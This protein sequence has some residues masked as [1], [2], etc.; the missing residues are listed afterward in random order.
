RWVTSAVFCKDPSPFPHTAHYDDLDRRCG[1]RRGDAYGHRFAGRPHQ[2][3]NAFRVCPCLSRCDY[4]TAQGGG[5]SAPIPRS[6]GS[7]ISNCWCP[8]LL[9]FDVEPA[10]G[11]MGAFCCLA[12]DW[13]VHLFPVRSAPQQTAARRGRWPNRRYSSAADQDVA[14]QDRTVAVAFPVTSSSYRSCFELS[15]ASGCHFGR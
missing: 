2:H 8:F 7:V 9:R 5:P 12:G 11:N 4:F 10:V 15:S 1:W 14:R 6:V 13:A 3:W